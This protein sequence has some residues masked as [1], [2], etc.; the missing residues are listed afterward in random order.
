MRNQPRIKGM[1]RIPRTSSLRKEINRAVEHAAREFDVS[2]S[3]I[4]SV[5]LADFFKIKTERY[6]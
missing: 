1:K 2:K 4:I 6:D 5:A 3:W